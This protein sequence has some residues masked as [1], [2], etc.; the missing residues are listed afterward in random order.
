[1]RV[2]ELVVNGTVEASYRI[3]DRDATLVVYAARDPE[4]ARVPRLIR[5]LVQLVSQLTGV[6]W[7]RGETTLM[8]GGSHAVP[9]WR[10]RL[11]GGWR[12]TRWGDGLV[13]VRFRY[14][15]VIQMRVRKERE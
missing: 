10:R 8:A 7:L 6:R 11:P 4:S 3:G 12:A 15:D 5:P 14:G 1:M 9:S 13:G 2:C